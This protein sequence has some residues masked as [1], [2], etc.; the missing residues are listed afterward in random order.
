[1]TRA[2]PSS[3]ITLQPRAGEDSA[4]AF[5][6]E[7]SAMTIL[8]RIDRERSAVQQVANSLASGYV[9][10][11]PPSA[12]RWTPRSAAGTSTP[13]A[14]H[15]AACTTPWAIARGG[16]PPAPLPGRCL[17]HRRHPRH[18]RPPRVAVRRPDRCGG[19]RISPNRQGHRRELRPVRRCRGLH[20]GAGEVRRVGVRGPRCGRLAGDNHP[21]ASPPAPL[22]R[23][24]P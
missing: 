4:A 9:G 1:L 2:R 17:E 18:W 16:S 23:Y 5:T 19:R 20:A 7:V 12:S 15:L 22:R 6:Y 3:Y 13:S 21:D 8:P 11:S 24:G 14:R 10:P